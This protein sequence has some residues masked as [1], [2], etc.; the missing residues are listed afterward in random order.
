MRWCQEGLREGGGADMLSM[1]SLA[2]GSWGLLSD[3]E[4]ESL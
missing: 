3:H 1:R 2:L 4:K